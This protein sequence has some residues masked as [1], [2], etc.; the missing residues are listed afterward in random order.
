[1]LSAKPLIATLVLTV[2]TAACIGAAGP[3]PMTSAQRSALAQP[4]GN[5][6]PGPEQCCLP[7][8]RTGDMVDSGG[9][10][11]SRR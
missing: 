3:H 5:R 9:Y 4:L 8:L 11:L 7:R 2:A 10:P 1:M 6:I